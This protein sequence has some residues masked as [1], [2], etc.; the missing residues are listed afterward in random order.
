MPTKKGLKII[1]I[2]HINRT[3]PSL[4]LTPFLEHL[5]VVFIMYVVYVEGFFSSSAIAIFHR[6]HFHGEFATEYYVFLY[7]QSKFRKQA[8]ACLWK[9]LV[10]AQIMLA[11]CLFIKILLSVCLR[12]R[13]D[14]ARNMIIL[15]K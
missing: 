4:T 11:L 8:G 5:T 13:L 6:K 9:K 7:K 12:K 3:A 14:Q 15:E 2:Q 10:Q 1:L